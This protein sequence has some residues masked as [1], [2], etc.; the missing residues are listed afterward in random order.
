MTYTV[1]LKLLIDEGTSE[2]S[3]IRTISTDHVD[4][5]KCYLRDFF[6]LGMARRLAVLGFV[7][8]ICLDSLVHL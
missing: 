5:Y 4:A 8:L 1:G 7:I 6:G 3:T 2:A